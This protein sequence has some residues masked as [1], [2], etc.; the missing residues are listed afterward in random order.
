MDRMSVA[1]LSNPRYASS[2]S[3][4]GGRIAPLFSHAGIAIF[5]LGVASGTPVQT[6]GR[7]FVG[8]LALMAIAPVVAIL[9]FGLHNQYGKTARLLLI[10]MIV[11]WLGYLVSDI[12]RG[13]ASIDYMRGWSRWIAMGASFAT[14][15][16]LGSKNIGYMSSFLIG[17]SVGNCLSPFAMGFNPG[18]ILYWK[19]YAGVPVVIVALVMASR[20]RPWVSVVALLAL[21]MLSLSLD[22]RSA[23]L[24]CMI[25]AGVTL[26]A[27]RRSSQDRLPLAPVGKGSIIAAAVLIAG[28]MVAAVYAVQ[29]FGARYG[30][31][32]RYQKSN[33]TRLADAIVA[34]SAISDSPMIGYGSWPR[35]A[36]LAR[37]RDRLVEKYKGAPAFRGPSQEDLI[38]SHSQI[39]QGWVEGGLLGLIFFALLAWQLGRQLLWQTISTPLTPLTPLIVFVQLNCAWHL[40]FSPFSGSQRLYIP[41]AGVFICYVAEQASQL[42]QIRK[43]LAAPVFGQ[44]RWAST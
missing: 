2:A 13:T 14:L 16:W 5:L 36:E 42:K 23:A 22:T 19:F 38:I 32:D 34:W 9:L 41:A 27:A 8:E 3:P 44:Q 11:S 40:V 4:D 30:Y 26:L 7:L 28:L 17:L 31:T 15:A 25:T 12:I 6:V 20:F 39:L 21:A 10:A 37:E 24:L 43:A 35:H 29:H 33:S 18:L 1:V